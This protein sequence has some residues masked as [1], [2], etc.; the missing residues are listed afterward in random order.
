M[1]ATSCDQTVVPG[2]LYPAVDPVPPATATPLMLHVPILEYHRVVPL[3]QAGDSLPGLT[4]PPEIFDAQM[5]ALHKAGW[6]TI[7]LAALAHDLAAGT[8]PPARTFVVTV[9]DGWWDSYDYVYSTLQKYGYVAT[10]FVIAGRIGRPNFMGPSQIRALLAAG[11]EI[12]DHT[13]T[14]A[15]LT[16]AVPKTLTWEIDAGAA[17]IAEVSG[18][19]PETLAYP[20]GKA[21]PA[22]MAAVT[23]CKSLRMAVMEGGGG[24]ETWSDRFRVARIQ[25]GSER[26]AADLLAQVQREGRP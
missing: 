15:V 5:A 23:A 11:N 10:F 13:V 12:G 19:W 7:T 18:R 6:N 20:H 26:A 21:D 14:H 22:V 2:A 16:A 4:M 17:T 8:R 24:R 25:V 1:A 9:D 3:A